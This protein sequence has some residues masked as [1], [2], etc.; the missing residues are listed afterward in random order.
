MKSTVVYV[1]FSVVHSGQKLNVSWYIGTRRIIAIV[2]PAVIGIHVMFALPFFVK[3]GLYPS[4]I[5]S[6]FRVKSVSNTTYRRCI[7]Q[8]QKTISTM[9]SSTRCCWF[10]TNLS[11][12]NAGDQRAEMARVILITGKNRN[13][14][15]APLHRF[16]RRAFAFVWFTGIGR[17]AGEIRCSRRFQI[18]ACRDRDF[19]GHVSFGR[20]SLCTQYVVRR[21]YRRRH[22]CT[23]DIWRYQSREARL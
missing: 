8:A 14:I 1:G 9:M 3:R 15:S 4:S 11:W 17:I 18:L 22:N 20:F 7:C 13:A 12:Q 19:G 5:W 16:V 2:C 21:R 23:P 6:V 10:T